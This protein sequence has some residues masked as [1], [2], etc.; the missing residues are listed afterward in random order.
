M[1]TRG[2]DRQQ[3]VTA[4]NGNKGTDRQQLV[5][6]KNGNMGHRQTAISDS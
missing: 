2:T 3:L 5:T 1:A 6:A 4:K